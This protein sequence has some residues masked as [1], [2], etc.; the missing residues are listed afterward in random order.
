MHRKHMVHAQ[1]AYG[2]KLVGLV[3]D[4]DVTT[5]C[6]AQRG[7]KR[8]ASTTSIRTRSALPLAS[9]SLA[10]AIVD[11][12]RCMQRC[13]R[14]IRAKLCTVNRPVLHTA[15][16]W[17]GCMT[18][19]ILCGANL[20]VPGT[21]DPLDPCLA[22]VSGVFDASFNSLHTLGDAMLVVALTVEPAFLLARLLQLHTLQ[23]QSHC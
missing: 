13:S 19:T 7:I 12:A 10:S 11:V 3:C 6:T 1:K 5:Q 18:S 23:L 17:L 22:Q 14:K 21:L 2:P 16:Q 8:C 4:S 20:V 15:T 9:S